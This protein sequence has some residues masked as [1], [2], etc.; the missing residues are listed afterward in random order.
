MD[1]QEKKLF[2]KLAKKHRLK[3]LTKAD[4]AKLE[5][6]MDVMTLAEI[7]EHGHHDMYQDELLMRDFWSRENAI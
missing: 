1:R 3:T 4:T 5:S 7:R 2:S 6:M